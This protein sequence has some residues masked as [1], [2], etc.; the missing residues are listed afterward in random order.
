M[1]CKFELT[2]QPCIDCGKPTGEL[3]TCADHIYCPQCKQDYLGANGDNVDSRELFVWM[4][5]KAPYLYSGFDDGDE[6]G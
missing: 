4:A 2:E 5:E 6:N 3:G 1:D